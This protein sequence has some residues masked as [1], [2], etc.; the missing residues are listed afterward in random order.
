MN[1]VNKGELSLRSFGPVVW[2]NMLPQKLKEITDLVKFKRE[3]KEWVP[4]NCVCRLCKDFVPD[5]GYATL[6]E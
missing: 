4:D 6:Y 2:D 3:I 5:L 1:T